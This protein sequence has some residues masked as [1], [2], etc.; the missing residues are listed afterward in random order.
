MSSWGCGP[1][2]ND[3]AADFAADLDEAP[4]SARLGMLHTAL[5]AV[6]TCGDYVDGA[7]AEVALAAVALVARD[8]TG[9]AEF[10]SQHYG[11]ANRLPPIPK[12]MISLAVEVVDRL[13]NGE[14]DVKRYWSESSEVDNWFAAM[15]RLRTVLAGDVPSSMDPL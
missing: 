7:R 3:T 9:G 2:D 4:E 15:R 10:Q 6:D 12:D 11:P 8:L 5:T 14:N 13:L 1:F